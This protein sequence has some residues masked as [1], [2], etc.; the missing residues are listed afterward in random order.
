M[1]ERRSLYTKPQYMLNLVD[2]KK[3]K[4]AVEFSQLFQHHVRLAQFSP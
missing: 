1:G 3:L 4:K 2:I